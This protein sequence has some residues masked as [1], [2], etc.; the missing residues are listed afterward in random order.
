MESLAADAG[1]RFRRDVEVRFRD[2]DAM[3]NAHHTLPLIY[4]EE[5]RA[6]YWREV[7]GR[8]T[9][10]EIDYIVAEFHVRYHERILYPATVSVGVRVARLGT[11]SFTMEYELRGEDGRLL[12]SARSV[13]VMYDYV[14]GRSIGVPEEVRGRVLGYEGEGEE[15][16]RQGHGHGHGQGVGR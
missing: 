7:A 4:F 13:Q 8:A 2:I 5:A 3:G 16:H 9:V 11:K 6:A 12:A 14:E 15:G 10:D 1:F